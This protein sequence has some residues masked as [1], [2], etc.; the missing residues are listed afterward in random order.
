[1]NSAEVVQPTC[2]HCNGIVQLD[3]S[4]CGTCGKEIIALQLVH[5]VDHSEDAFTVLQ[6]TLAYYGITLLLLA[7]Y[8]LTSVFPEGFDGMVAITI[9]DTLIVLTFCVLFYRQLLP[10]FSL[11]NVKPELVA[12][13]ALCAMVGSVVVSVVADIINI[14]ISDDVFYSTYLFE[15]TSHPFLFAVLF[16]AVHPAI[17][18]EVTFR[19]FIFTNVSRIATPR[20]AIYITGFVFGIIHLAIISLLWLVPIGLIFAWLRWKHNTLWYGV[21]GHFV[22]NLCIT[23]IEYNGWTLY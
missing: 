4:F 5:S 15:D 18:E 9:I 10:L 6:P 21:V 14:S 23:V 11:R 20:S 7:T 13:T 19:G 1:M 16:I 2:P 17:F 3:D 22:Y 8:K 12:L